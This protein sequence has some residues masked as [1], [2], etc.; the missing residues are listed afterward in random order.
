VKQLVDQLVPELDK[1]N[2]KKKK[3]LFTE[4]VLEKINFQLLM[5]SRQV[6]QE[7]LQIE[8]TVDNS[9]TSGYKLKNVTYTPKNGKPITAKS[10][11]QLVAELVKILPGKKTEHLRKPK[12][13]RISKI[14]AEITP[15]ANIQND[16]TV[17]LL[18]NCLGLSKLPAREKSLQMFL[19]SC[20]FNNSGKHLEVPKFPFYGGSATCTSHA[21]HKFK[22]QKHKN[23]T[24]TLRE[25]NSFMSLAMVSA[26]AG[27]EVWQ[28]WFADQKQKDDDDDD[29]DGDTVN[30]DGDTV[31]GDGDGKTV[32]AGETKA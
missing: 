12:Y 10:V 1:S 8:L 28:R 15:N 13:G 2:E 16:L 25:H 31:N 18:S 19:R 32:T 9:T 11:K 26:M 30:G 7:D 22:T 27:H 4:Q 3:M 5:K 14:V 21:H 23:L 29:G 20:G 17:A 24:M 6:N